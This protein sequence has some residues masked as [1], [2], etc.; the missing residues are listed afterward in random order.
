MNLI[1][2][3]WIPFVTGNSVVLKSM[4]GLFCEPLRGQIRCP[5]PLEDVAIH[6]LLMTIA[7]AALQP[8]NTEEIDKWIENPMAASNRIREYLENWH[9]RFDLFSACC[10]FMQVGGLEQEKT[11]SVSVLCLARATGN[12]PALFDHSCDENPRGL[13][14]AEAARALLAHQAFAVALGKSP[15]V[16]IG[17]QQVARG[18]RKDGTCTRGLTIWLAGKTIMETILINLL[19]EVTG[20]PVWEDEGAY[21]KSDGLSQIESIPFDGLC[22]RYTMMS[23]MIR[24]I[25]D[26]DGMVRWIYYSMGRSEADEQGPDPMQVY[27]LN[28]KTSEMNRQSAPLSGLTWTLLGRILAPGGNRI[29][30]QAGKIKN[31]PPTLTLKTGGLRSEFGKAAKMIAWNRDAIPCFEK[32]IRD[33]EFQEQIITA[34]E[35]ANKGEA[36]LYGAKKQVFWTRLT[37]EFY[38]HLAG[39]SYGDE[40][41]AT[42]DKTIS[43]IKK[44]IIGGK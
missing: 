42:V 21:W 19:P 6:R 43:A 25:Q 37:P 23:R 24:L 2:S 13:S 3:P 33:K 15:T 38:R 20:T 34:I 27:Y 29:V 41:A 40:W 10:P 26:N 31:L 18:S 44:N 30:D 32:L 1:D 17:G 11:T 14:P 36:T 39:G 12:T 28:T 5:T 7:M 35:K 22:D 8:R 16:T 9:D 4:E